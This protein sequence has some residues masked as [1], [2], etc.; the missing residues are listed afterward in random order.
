[1]TQHAGSSA[2]AGYAPSPE[3][4]SRLAGIRYRTELL[5]QKH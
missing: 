1:M 3:W 5:N 4:A 2:T